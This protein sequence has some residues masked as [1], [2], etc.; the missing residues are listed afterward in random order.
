MQR[1]GR[2]RNTGTERNNEMTD[3]P[4]TSDL[5][6]ALAALD[7]ATLADIAGALWM[8]T[9]D[10]AGVPAE[11]AAALAGPKDS[12]RAHGER[13]RLFIEHLLLH[14]LSHSPGYDAVYRR[15]LEEVA[16]LS[17][18]EAYAI[19]MNFLGAPAS[20]GYDPVPVPAGLEFPRD[21]LPQPRSQV[22][23]HF[24]VGSCWSADGREFGVE[25]MFFQCAL[26]PPEVAAGFGLTDD[27]NQTVELQFAISEAGGRHWQAAPIVL[28]GTSGLVG[29]DADP[30][31]YRLGRNT[32]RCHTSGELLPLTITARGTDRGGD[33]PHVLA[34]EI[35]FSSGKQ[36]LL[37]GAGGCMPGVDGMGTLYY[38]V[39]ALQLDPAGSWIELDGERVE[40]TRGVFWFDHQ[41]GAI[42]GVPHSAV[43]RAANNSKEPAPGGWDWFMAQFDGD[44]QLT[45]FN[46]HAN[47]R[48]AFY[49]Q[50]GPTPPGTMTVN[51][52][53][54]F[55]DP[56]GETRIVRGTLDVTEWVRADHSP[57][58]ERYPVT[59][60]WYPT[61]WEFRFDEGVPEDIAVF[62]MTPIVAE[63]QSGFFAN[64]A[65][66]CE[67]AVVLHDAQGREAGRGFA[68][69]VA[70]ADTRR[71]VHLLAGLDAS[72]EAVAA[73]DKPKP[74]GAEKIAN[75]LYV[76]THKKQLEAIV[77]ASAG[78][79]FFTES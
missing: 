4:E 42:D 34:A 26:Y 47:A 59:G 28:A 48:R 57:D 10:P 25:L 67:G 30:F 65:Q 22:G 8:E 46:P 64:G 51:V 45:V 70:Y 23:W 5:A 63:A 11:A 52:A 68:E 18:H 78:L 61:H 49:Q 50:T 79:E 56:A 75:A 24:F 15:L 66:Y 27:E 35:T 37:Q 76:A 38:S 33:E 1:R 3:R 2:H 20:V 19:R 9:L 39:P 17:P 36:V 21:H 43:L 62:T 7:A 72:D 41:W 55:M 54:T 60:T 53:G 16:D 31:V 44:R 77:A 74:T 58:P 12:P 40:L 29:W 69:S 14:P 13:M 73:L 32:I 6:T 71:T